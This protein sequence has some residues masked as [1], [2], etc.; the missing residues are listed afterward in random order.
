ML[1]RAGKLEG[2]IWPFQAPNN[3]GQGAKLGDKDCGSLA[4]RESRGRGGG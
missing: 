1:L 3:K 4:H 2:S